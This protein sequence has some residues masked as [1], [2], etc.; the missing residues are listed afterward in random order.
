MNSYKAIGNPFYHQLFLDNGTPL[1][2]YV[3]HG[4]AISN[5]NKWD[6]SYGHSPEDVV[7]IGGTIPGNSWSNEVESLPDG[8]GQV[9]M[10]R[11]YRRYEKGLDLTDSH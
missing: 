7:D 2:F 8:P 3:D 11:E 5:P 10:S 1:F 9:S 4:W 6:Q